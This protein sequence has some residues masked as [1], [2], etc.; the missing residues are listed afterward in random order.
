MVRT[1]EARDAYANTDLP[2]AEAVEAIPDGSND[3][4]HV[5]T[6]GDAADYVMKFNTF[7]KF[8]TFK[9][10]VRVLRFLRNHSGLPVPEVVEVHEDIS[11]RPA[12]FFITRYIDG[13]SP[14]P[15][16]DLYQPRIIR[17]MGFATLALDTLPEE[18]LDGYGRIQPYGSNPDRLV[19]REDSWRRY[20]ADY[21]D[22]VLG[23]AERM[24]PD[25]FQPYVEPLREAI[26]DRLDTVPKEPDPAV[27]LPDFRLAN[28]LVSDD[29][30]V[31]GVLDFERADLGDAHLAL[32]NTHYLLSRGLSDAQSERV[33][34]DLAEGFAGW[35]EDEK[36][37]TYRL[38][39]LAKEVR[40]FDHWWD[41][42]P[43]DEYEGHADRLQAALDDAL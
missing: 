31:V 13:E 8:R 24:T 41:D 32:A 30:R 16:D 27:I 34:E 21:V 22:G 43:D 6:A 17:Q 4:F 26:F 20:Y 35:M 11:T 39:A 2:A 5:Q 36:Y 1:E 7:S 23:H 9:A 25:R 18:Q 14:P 42:L 37:E 33:R 28:L 12:P 38:G 15:L 19:A 29:R 40:A 3:S 10:E